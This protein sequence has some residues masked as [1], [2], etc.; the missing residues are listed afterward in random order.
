MNEIEK[1][2]MPKGYAI[3][4]III[5]AIYG[6]WMTFIMKDVVLVNYE[7]EAARSVTG[8]CYNGYIQ[9]DITGMMGRHWLYPIWV[10]VSCITLLLFIVYIKKILYAETLTKGISTICMILLI[11]GCVFVN[12]YGFFDVTIVK[13]GAVTQATFKDK[14]TFITAS[15]TGLQYPWHFRGWGVFASA[16]IFMNTMYTFRKYNYNSKLCV[17]LGSLGSAAIYMTINCPSYGV[18]KD[19]TVWRCLGHWA[20]AVI[21]AGCCAAPLIIFLLSKTIK[22]KG[23]YLGALIAFG[24]VLAALGVLTVAGYK[25]AVIENI[26]TTAAYILLFMLNFTHFFDKNKKAAD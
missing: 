5:T 23:R 15:M 9:P 7:T 17:I 8:D 24:L 14:L 6:C 20:G 10:I 3:M 25:S 12:W 11:F 26:P 13:D 22:E 16:S 19:F 2:Q 4:W 1:R 21:F 18:E